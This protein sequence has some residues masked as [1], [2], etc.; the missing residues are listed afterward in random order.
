MTMMWSR[1]LCALVLVVLADSAAPVAAQQQSGE[2][3][4]AILAVRGQG[5]VDVKP[6]VAFFIV[7][8]STQRLSL[9]EAAAAHQD[10]ATQALSALEGLKAAGIEIV[11]S[12]FRINQDR[13]PP[14]PPGPPAPRPAKPPELPFTAETTFSLKT[15]RIGEL[16][17]IVSKLA[18]SGLIEVRTVHFKVEQERAVLNQARR[19][20]MMDAR[21]QAD[22]YADAGALNLVE[23]IEITDG[24]AAPFDGAADLAVPRFVQIIPP[25]TVEFDASVN[26]TWRI[27]PR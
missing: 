24:Q 26:V 2:H 3:R 14:Q 23:I 8:V 16:N 19:A 21:E 22:T 27:A 5:K 10:R 1:A 7:S 20:A 11:S 12:S 6:D 15:S 9:G 4:A 18:A 17:A 25:A 13:P